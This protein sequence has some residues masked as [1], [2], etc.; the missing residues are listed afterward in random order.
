MNVAMNTVPCW[1]KLTRNGD[2]FKGY[3]SEDGNAWEPAS[4]PIT[5]EIRKD[6][7]AGL[8]VTSG[9]RDESRLHTSHFDKVVVS[10]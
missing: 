8:A 5:V 2:T 6:V 4:D 9:S 10:E 1:V 7:Y 3:I